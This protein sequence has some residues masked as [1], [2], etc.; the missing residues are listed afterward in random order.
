MLKLLP[1]IISALLLAAHFLRAGWLVLVVLSLVFPLLLLFRHLWAT[2]AV[3]AILILGA[4]EW[5]RTLLALIDERQVVGES[6]TAAAI[7]LGSVALF[8]AASALPIHHI[9]AADRH[10]N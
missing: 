3:Q 9:G 1:V 5:V 8:T 6:W 10:G 2:R 4:L 7:I